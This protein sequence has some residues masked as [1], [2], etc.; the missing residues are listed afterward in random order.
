M[1]TA[2]ISDEKNETRDS[3][4][5]I[6]GVGPSD[7]ADAIGTTFTLLSRATTMTSLSQLEGRL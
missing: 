4:F 3:M 2:S 1:S 5:V 7:M 6:V